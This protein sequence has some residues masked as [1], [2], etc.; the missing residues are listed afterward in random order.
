[1]SQAFAASCRD[2]LHSVYAGSRFAG[3]RPVDLSQIATLCIG[4]R[5][6]LS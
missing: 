6:S 3:I 1:M 2:G 5:H 4:R